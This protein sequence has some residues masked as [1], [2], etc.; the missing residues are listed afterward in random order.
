MKKEMTTMDFLDRAV[1]LY[2]DVVGVIADD[3]TEYTYAE[4][5]ERVNSLANVLADRGIGQGDRVAMLASNTH[6]F[7]EALYATNHL[8]A[9]YVPMNYRLVPENYEYILN[10]CEA[11][12]VI[13]DYDFAEKV[14]AVRDSVPAETF[15][16]YEADEIDGDWEDYMTLVDEAS[17][18]PPERA[19]LSEDDDASINYTSGTTGDPKGVVRTHRTEHWHALVLNQHM[20][21]RDDDTYLWTLPM[22]HCNGWGHTYAITGTGGTHVCLRKFTPERTLGKIR[23][24]DVS[25]MCGAPT[26]L[27]R[28][29]A[30]KENNPDVET[31]GDRELRIATAGSAPATATIETVEDDIS[32]RII[33]IYGLTETAPIITTSNSPRRLATRGRSLKVKQGSEV[34]GTDVRVVHDDGTDVPADGQT[35]GEVVVRGNQV[36]DRYLNKPEATEEAFNDR[37]SGYF[38]TG[39]L[40]TIDEDGMISIQD[41]KKDII[42]SGGENV[43]SIEV[44]D[45][46]YDHPEIAKAAVIPTPSDEWGELVTAVVVPKPGVELSDADVE[47]F[48]RDRMA[49]YKIPR[50]I[51]VQEDLPE[52]ATGKVQKYQLRKEF[53]EDEDRL[54]GQG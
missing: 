10:D 12:V 17:A 29:I 30:Y 3:G 9:V 38:H 4:F 43:S 39:D 41:R 19:D 27:N 34:L 40:A 54:I 51:L 46:L 20:E 14:E 44:E 49:G 21:I 23:N 1:D 28:V 36:M 16:G 8:G 6:Y 42:I 13:A 2:D 5:N 52:T 18:D 7:L 37:I 48:C 50:K 47:D 22:F 31:T 32:W 25:F 11:S 24:H 35:M 45:V 15:I 26:V 53:W 33:H